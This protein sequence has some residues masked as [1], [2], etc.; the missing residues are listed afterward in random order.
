MIHQLWSVYWKRIILVLLGEAFCY[1]PDWWTNLDIGRWSL[2]KD[3][4]N[5]NESAHKN[6]NLIDWSL[7]VI[8]FPGK[9]IRDT[10]TSLRLIVF[11]IGKVWYSWLKSLFYNFSDVSRGR[12]CFECA[13][14]VNGFPSLRIEEAW[15]IS[16]LLHRMRVL[17]DGSV[18]LYY[19]IPSLIIR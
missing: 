19:G 16:A 14:Y 15:H 13:F 10:P 1:C 11:H 12:S 17:I 5:L 18:Q 3:R 4:F 6:L 8:N 7:K 2:I 9:W